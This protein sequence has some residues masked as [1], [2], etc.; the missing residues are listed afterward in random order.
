MCMTTAMT[1]AALY[2]EP[3][4]LLLQDT[5]IISIELHKRFAENRRE[6]RRTYSWYHAAPKGMLKPKMRYDAT[7]RPNAP[8]LS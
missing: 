2:D 6:K 3:L 5:I 8:F 4:D 1:S 7:L